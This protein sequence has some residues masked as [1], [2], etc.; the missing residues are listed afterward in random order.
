VNPTSPLPY[1]PIPPRPLLLR[2]LHH[3]RH[4]PTIP[5]YSTAA[6]CSCS[7]SGSRDLWPT[8]SLLYLLFLPGLRVKTR[9]YLRLSAF[10]TTYAKKMKSRNIIDKRDILILLFI[11]IKV[12][13][14]L[15]MRHAHNVL[16]NN[17]QQK[18]SKMPEICQS[19]WCGI[20]KPGY[21]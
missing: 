4:H 7:L 14:Q 2:P 19:E 20:E 11:H 21:F 3:R 8:P 16:A 17:I 1:P 12:I 15:K 5:F 9:V 13:K 6:K 18:H 10:E